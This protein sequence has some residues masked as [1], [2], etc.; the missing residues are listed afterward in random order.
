MKN[1]FKYDFIKKAIVGSKAA[2]K[3]ANSGNGNEYLELCK[4]LAEHPDFRVVPKEI[5]VNATKKK[6]NGLTF[7]RM[8]E[9]IEL[10]ED[11]EIVLAVFKKVQ[12]IAEAKGAKYP[13]TKKWFLS[14]YPEY[15]ENEASI[16]SNEE[17]E[18]QAEAEI[19]A[20]LEENAA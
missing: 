11:K 19:E 7:N 17:I 1:Y 9:Y 8:K 18:K 20:I 3:R 16:V 10:Q 4:M 2:I 6:Y 14:K 15:K 5:E 13:L 12:E